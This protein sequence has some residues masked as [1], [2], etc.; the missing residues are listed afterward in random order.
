[1]EI[2]RTGFNTANEPHPSELLAEGGTVGKEVGV[3]ELR[4]AIPAYCFKPSLLWSFFYLLRDLFYS[5]CLLLVLNYCLGLSTVQ[6]SALIYYTV[7]NLYGFCQGIV[8]TGLWVIAHDSG[9]GGFSQSSLLNDIV[10]FTLHSALLAPYFSWKSTHRR[11]HI[12]ANHIEKDLN[13]VPPQREDYARR[14]GVAIE[15]LEEVAEDS[16]LVQF[17]R[18]ILQ[19]VIGWNWYILSNITCPKTAVI[20]KNMSLWRY[21]HFDPWGG[22][23]RNS[24]VWSII[25]SDIGCLTTIAA[26]YF[27]SQQLQSFELMCWIYVV[28]WCWVNH[29]IVMITFLHH[30]HPSVPKYS[31]ESWTF[32]RGATATIDRDFGII[33]THFFHHI[34]SNH[35][36]HHLFSS[37]PHYYSPIASKAIIPLL[38]KHYHGRGTFTYSDLQVSFSDCQFVEEDRDKDNAF[39][40]KGEKDSQALWYRKGASPQPEY[41]QRGARLSPR[42]E[43]EVV[44]EGDQEER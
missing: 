18:I 27:L 12:Y 7:V 26:L 21:S 13:Y 25:L 35:V 37:I 38:G 22:M 16:P 33:G 43:K 29:W 32:I 15:A 40:L 11:H 20:K 9:H 28:P 31:P 36:T 6:D 10:G 24:E 42:L 4:T 5:T 23:F 30:T 8:W 14:L 44:K 19:Q 39:G 41:H 1:M 3:Q 17:L 2:D 34:S